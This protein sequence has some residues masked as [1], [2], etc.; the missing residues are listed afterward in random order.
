[1][2]DE[3][4]ETDEVKYRVVKDADIERYFT[5]DL[6]V[7]DDD[8]Y[9]NEDGDL[10]AAVVEFRDYPDHETLTTIFDDLLL[11]AV[12]QTQE[13]DEEEAQEFIDDCEDEEEFSAELDL[14]ETFSVLF[15]VDGHQGLYRM[16]LDNNDHWVG[17]SDGTKHDKWDV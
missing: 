8:F 14:A 16:L 2:E 9:Y 7:D 11:K 13:C 3:Q 10:L 12:M 5:F 1:M 17:H 4:N 15:T 6:E